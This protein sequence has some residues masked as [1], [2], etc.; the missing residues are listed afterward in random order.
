METRPD[1]FSRLRL[2]VCA[3]IC[4]VLSPAARCQQPP[5]P[6]WNIAPDLQ[7]SNQEIRQLLSS[8]ESKSLAG[9]YESAFAD[10][11]RLWS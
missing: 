11:K 10:K 6:Q 7:A 8:A 9:E 3:C 1:Y 5:A 4:F 2:L